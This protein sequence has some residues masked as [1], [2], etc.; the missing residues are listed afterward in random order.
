MANG[1]FMAVGRPR[2]VVDRAGASVECAARFRGHS[3]EPAVQT[4][5]FFNP[6]RHSP[7]SRG[8]WLQ[9]G[10]SN[11]DDVPADHQNDRPR[12]VP[13]PVA[14]LLAGSRHPAWEP[15]M[16]GVGPGASMNLDGRQP[17]QPVWRRWLL[18]A[19]TAIIGVVATVFLSLKI[20]DTDRARSIAELR[21]RA[22]LLSKNIENRI[23]DVLLPLSALA[24][25]L[26]SQPSPTI[27]VF[28]AT[29]RK[30]QTLGV[31]IARLSWQPR[32]P[33]STRRSFEAEARRQGL[34]DYQILKL[35]PN[36]DLVPADPSEEYVPIRLEAVDQGFPS[37]MGFDLATEPVRWAA[38]EMARDTGRPIGVFPLLRQVV[39]RG[40]RVYFVGWPLFDAGP[41][42]ETT[43]DRRRR[44]TGFVSAVMPLHH[45]I[46]Y[47][48]EHSGQ[49]VE[50]V[51][52]QVMDGGSDKGLKPIALVSPGESPQVLPADTKPD[53]SGQIVFDFKFRDPLQ[54]WAVSVSY[55]SGALRMQSWTTGG[56][57]GGLSL[58]ATAALVATLFV[59][60]RNAERDR[61][62]RLGVET[63]MTAVEDT[64]RALSRANSNL[65]DREQA[66]VALARD[67][68]RFLAAAS[69][70]LRKPLH[71]LSLFTAALARRVTGEEATE[72]VRS[73]AEVEASLQAMFNSLLDLSRLDMGAVRARIAPVE[74]EPL[75][76]KLVAEFTPLAREKGLSLRVAGR[77]P[78]VL[79][80]PGLLESVLRNLLGNAIKFTTQGG[81]LVAGRRRDGRASI[82]VWDTGP[83]IPS[84][85]ADEIFDEFTRLENTAAMPGFGLGLP[86]A[87][88]LCDLI[89]ASLNLWSRPGRGSRFAVSL[90]PAAADPS[91][92]DALY[93]TTAVQTRRILVVDD[94][95]GV[96]RGL[97]MELADQ[98]HAVT[99]A[100]TFKEALDL[101]DG[102][103]VFEFAI[104]D[105]NLSGRI[106]GWDLV[107]AWRRRRPGRPVIVM[108]GNT[109]PETLRRVDEWRLPTLFKPVRAEALHEAIANPAALVQDPGLSRARS[110][111][112]GCARQ[113]RGRSRR[114]R[115]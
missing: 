12:L 35:G 71:A 58:A 22:T 44:L 80:D 66:S 110:L 85:K 63:L 38:L 68:T 30:L 114:R 79:T 103:Q 98:G 76:R 70:D 2:F 36:G 21:S 99:T 87:R 96:L 10:Y 107:S 72:L 89:G 95:P 34:R 1:I 28:R 4:R 18:C 88:R 11:D 106:E 86:I 83:G 67:R 37:A 75:V 92:I 52:F 53:M 20:A 55:P 50:S 104:F 23:E 93:A 27:E 3:R 84:D 73:I 113:A 41:P 31:P 40:R 46:A 17:A 94:E 57:V 45:V 32:I 77:F 13:S 47:A 6:L 59:V 97:A 109:D 49:T 105:L 16:T 5:D 69:H 60:M 56:L 26:E 7:S 43:A 29:A 15:F 100:A 90:P 112:P 25:F 14:S 102:A 33:G 19:A 101:I 81:V 51:L 48:M 9:P 24:V 62:Q 115:S 74:S 91:E 61:N 82:E 8:Q 65:L 39:V 64:N 108:T 42:P 111:P 78:C 54:Q